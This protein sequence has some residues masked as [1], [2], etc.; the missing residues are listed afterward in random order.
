MTTT[1]STV[2]TATDSHLNIKTKQRAGVGGG[3]E[4]VDKEN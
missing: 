3:R 1:I 2:T 4:V